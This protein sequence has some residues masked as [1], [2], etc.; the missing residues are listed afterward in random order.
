MSVYA[1]SPLLYGGIVDFLDTRLAVPTTEEAEKEEKKQK[2]LNKDAQKA[3]SKA[4]SK[5]EPKPDAKT[6]LNKPLLQVH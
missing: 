5:V 2:W 4:A 1:H 3:G 6:E